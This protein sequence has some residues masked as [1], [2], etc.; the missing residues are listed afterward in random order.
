MRAIH[1]RRNLH[2]S[3]RHRHPRR[4]LLLHGG[5]GRIEHGRGGR[6]RA[7]PAALLLGHLC[8]VCMLLHLLL[9]LLERGLLLCKELLVLRVLRVLGV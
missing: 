8:L 2:P 9:V 1:P 3:L 5:H 4:Q 7:A 6:G